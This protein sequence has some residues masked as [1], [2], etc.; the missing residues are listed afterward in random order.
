MP[1]YGLKV[2]IS[3]KPRLRW[4]C[5]SQVSSSNNILM[6]LPSDCCGLNKMPLRSL[7]HVD[8]WPPSWW[9][10]GE[11]FEV[12]SCWSMSLG[13]GTEVSPFWVITVCFL[14]VVW[15]VNCGHS[16]CH[17]FIPPSWTLTLKLKAH[18]MLYFISCLGHGVF[19]HSNETVTKTLRKIA[20]PCTANWVAKGPW[21]QSS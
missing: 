18:Y 4:C 15:D 12:W 21:K 19:Y 17:D 14:F 8:C 3:N 9:L 1:A 7:W 16:C 20:A 11:A 6:D 5:W 2:C 13:E 10:F